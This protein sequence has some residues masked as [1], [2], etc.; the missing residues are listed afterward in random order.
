MKKL[1]KMLVLTLAL[2]L[3]LS[4]AVPALAATITVNNTTKDQEYKAYKIFDVVKNGDSYAYSIAENSPWF[5]VVKTYHN[6]HP[7]TR[8]FRANFDTKVDGKVI[9][10]AIQQPDTA[11][12]K[13][14][15][16][17]FADYLAANIPS[18]ATCFSK[19]STADDSSVII[20]VGTENAV[21]YY[22]VTSSLGSLCVLKTATDSVTIDEKNT[23]PYILKAATPTT[24][25][26]G[27]QVNFV[28]TVAANNGAN[29]AYI[30]EDTMS[31]GLSFTPTKEAFTIIR[32]TRAIATDIQTTVDDVPVL[33]DS[34]ELT[35]TSTET[36]AGF[37]IVFPPE[38]TKDLTA[39]DD[40]IISYVATLNDKA[41]NSNTEINKVKFTYNEIVKEAEA[42]VIKHGFS[43]AKV[44]TDNVLIDSPAQFKLYS[45]S[46][47][48]DADEIKLVKDFYQNTDGTD[49]GN[50]CYRP[51]LAN[52]TPEEVIEAG[53]VIIDGLGNG[54]YYL[55][56]IKA[57]DNYNKVLTPVQVTIN[58]ADQFNTVD[59]ATKKV[60]G[61][62]QVV[63]RRGS[64]MPETGG[65]GTT[66]FYILGGILLVGAGVLL[67]TRKRMSSAK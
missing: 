58:S 19:T 1:K 63:N 61:G 4:I 11:T 50:M 51:A 38:F 22:F 44:N 45:N 37:K 39:N 9:I 47:C 15:A 2:M 43:L 5:E 33:A 18:G 65:I 24:A 25:S 35:D 20:D 67:V 7:N 46:N 36:N 27:G 42:T 40:I 49:T 3:A 10:A 62:I 60:T 31:P 16:K 6:E 8:P 66:I 57:P 54:V 48:Q 21:G 64:V 26:V 41:I 53:N 29:S 32:R 28:L 17:D 34:Y 55:K 12:N 13:Q 30:L 52:E 56:E 59:A 14:N 23:R